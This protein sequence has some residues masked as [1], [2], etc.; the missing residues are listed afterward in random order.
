MARYQRASAR[1]DLVRSSN[2]MPGSACSCSSAAPVTSSVPASNWI[3]KGSDIWIG[4]IQWFDPA[5]DRSILLKERSVV[6][7]TKG[8]KVIRIGHE[9][10]R[11]LIDSIHG[12]FG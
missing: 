4:A 6:A 2:W 1:C 5:L 9:L 8:R 7:Q 3:R 11:K 10:V 12:E